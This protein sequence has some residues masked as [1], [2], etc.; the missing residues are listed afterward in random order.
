MRVE[1]PRVDQISQKRREP[2]LR[3]GFSSI[4]FHKGKSNEYNSFSYNSRIDY[5]I[6][7][8]ICCCICGLQIIPNDVNMCM[9]CLRTELGMHGVD[10]RQMELVQCGKCARW[11]VRQDK[12]MHF[13]MESTQLLAMLLRKI[14]GILTSCT[15]LDASWIWTEPHSRRIKINVDVERSVLD[16]KAQIRHKIIVEFTV[17]MKQCLECI[18]EAT[19]HSWET[20]VQI[21]QRVRVKRS[22]EAVESMLVQGGYYH[23][24]SNMVVAKDGLDLYFKEK[25]QAER[26]VE[27][28]SVNFPTKS[29]LSKKLVSK[30][31][32]SN[33]GNYEYTILLEVAPLCKG[34]L[35]MFKKEVMVVHRVTSSIHLVSASSALRLEIQ[36]NVYFG[37]PIQVLLS[38][39][40]LVPFLV[41][42]INPVQGGLQK[43]LRMDD[44]QSQADGNSILAEAEVLYI[45]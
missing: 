23:L 45:Y 6:R 38:A 34:D 28:L 42:D 18:R 21:R 1:R 19:D 40:Q 22:L 5:S 24:I 9:D 26:V 44:E 36:A 25:Q 30:D 7:M 14:S 35:V 3:F 10:E 31:G 4:S 15:I 43:V 27:F 11:H 29:K 17:K 20:C 16:N 8:S 41:L 39:S 37:K 2:F 33:L 12:W 13:E 32:K